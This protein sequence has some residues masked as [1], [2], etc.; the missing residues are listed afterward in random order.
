MVPLPGDRDYR[1]QPVL[2]EDLAGLAVDY[3][4]GDDNI[5]IDA[6][7]PEVFTCVELV[8]LVRTRIRTRCWVLPAPRWFTYLAGRALGMVLGGTVLTKN[9][10]TGLSRNLFVSNSSSLPPA[11]TRLSEWLEENGDKLGRDYASEVARH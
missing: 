9:E 8:G 7:G 6:V 5:E 4:I 1:I 11:P 2:V 10:I 3:A